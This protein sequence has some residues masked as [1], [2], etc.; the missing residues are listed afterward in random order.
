MTKRTILSIVVAT[1]LLLVTFG[2]VYSMVLFKSN[3]AFEFEDAANAEEMAAAFGKGEGGLE[4]AGGLMSRL[5]FWLANWINEFAADYVSG[6]QMMTIVMSGAISCFTVAANF[7]LRKIMEVMTSFERHS[8]LSNFGVSLLHKLSAVYICNYIVVYFFVYS[9][10]SLHG[11]SDA[12]H[13]IVVDMLAQLNIDFSSWGWLHDSCA[14]TEGDVS[15]CHASALNE[16]FADA[17]WY[18]DTGLLPQMVVIALVD[19]TFLVGNEV[20]EV[21]IFPMLSIAWG[22]LTKYSQDG[23]DEAYSPPQFK[24]ADKYAY[25][26]KHVAI[27]LTFGSA[28]PLLY[29]ICFVALAMMYVCQKAALVMYYARPSVTEDSLAEAFRDQLTIL[30]FMHVAFSFVFYAKQEFDVY[31][32]GADRYS[33]FALGSAPFGVALLAAFA[34]YVIPFEQM[35]ARDVKKEASG[36][37]GAGYSSYFKAASYLCPTKL[38][39]V[40][41]ELEKVM[42]ARSDRVKGGGN[43]RIRKAHVF[44]FLGEK[45]VDIVEGAIDKI[46]P[47]VKGCTCCKAKFE[48]EAQEMV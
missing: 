28:C 41:G 15:E 46:N 3:M 32:I 11:L 24:L 7:A 48:K 33:A 43:V 20:I 1:V 44:D 9:A 14:D 16:A 5:S 37:K 29:C 25:I 10:V 36:T 22:R 39:Q 30:L 8:S 23:L 18:S 2:F 21:F 26:I 47:C 38:S 27:C 12:L 42:S 19:A 17:N 45:N 4:E 35:L 34:Y 31:G 40:D 13:S 6:N